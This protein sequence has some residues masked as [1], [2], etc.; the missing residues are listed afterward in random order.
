MSFLLVNFLNF[1]FLKLICEL[2]FKFIIYLIIQVNF[3]LFFL[4]IFNLFDFNQFFL[5]IL[6]ILQYFLILKLKQTCFSM[7]LKEIWIWFSF[8]K[9]CLFSLKLKKLIIIVFLTFFLESHDDTEFELLN[10]A[11]FVN[12]FI[13][14]EILN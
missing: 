11:F 4:L 6:D 3:L 1:M 14:V 9:S 8:Y 2:I 10:Y 12:D 7:K 5:I 13:S